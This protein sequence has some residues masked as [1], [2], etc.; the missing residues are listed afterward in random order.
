MV[1]AALFAAPPTLLQIAQILVPIQQSDNRRFDRRVYFKRPM[2]HQGVAARAPG[3]IG[4]DATR[5][6]DMGAFRAK[7]GNRLSGIDIDPPAFKDFHGD[8]LATPRSNYLG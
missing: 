3:G 7:Y 1:N 8:Y 6:K 5:Q 2:Q 4:I